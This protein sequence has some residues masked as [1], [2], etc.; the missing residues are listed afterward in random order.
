MLSQFFRPCFAFRQADTFVTKQLI[1]FGNRGVLASQVLAE[2]FYLRL[3][4]GF[5]LRQELLVKLLD[6]RNPF[7]NEG[8]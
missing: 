8:I 6:L 1:C 4:T 3:V 2:F 5:G 7:W